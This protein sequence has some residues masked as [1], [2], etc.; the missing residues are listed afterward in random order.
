MAD[1]WATNDLTVVTVRSQLQIPLGF[2]QIIGGGGGLG[3]SSSPATSP[4]SPSPSSR[5]VFGNNYRQDKLNDL[6]LILHFLKNRFPGRIFDNFCR[7]IESSVQ[8]CF[9]CLMFSCPVS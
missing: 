5:F 3:D 2:S 8:S 9:F 6:D 1:G 4:T 7:D